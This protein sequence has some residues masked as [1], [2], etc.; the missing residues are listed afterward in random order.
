MVGSQGEYLMIIKIPI[1]VEVKGSLK[2]TSYLIEC[3]QASMERD[4]L[5]SPKTGK[6]LKKSKWFTLSS[7]DLKVQEEFGNLLEG[8]RYISRSEVLEIM[9]KQS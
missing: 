4:Y 3:F 5:T 7:K 6:F 8:Y 1:Y 9:R 2:E